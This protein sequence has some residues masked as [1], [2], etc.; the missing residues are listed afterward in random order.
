MNAFKNLSKTKLFYLLICSFFISNLANAQ[1]PILLED[2]SFKT[3]EKY[4]RIKNLNTYYVAANNRLVSIKKGRNS[5]TIQRFNLEDL[6]EDIK[7]RQVIEDKGDFQTVMKLNDKAVV[8]YTKSNRAYGQKVS[9][10]GI[11]AE[12]PIQLVNDKESVAKDFGFKSTYGYDAGGRINQFVFKKS[13]NGR[14]LLVLFRIKTADNKP[15][16]VGVTVFSDGLNLLWRRKVTMPHPSNLMQGEDFAIDDNGNFYMTASFF[17]EVSDDKDKIETSYVTEV[18]RITENSGPVAANKLSISGHSITDGVI[19]F[20]NSGKARVSGFYANNANKAE[21]SGVFSATLG[22]DGAV[23]SITKGD[24]SG[25]INQKWILEREARIN[26]G[27]QKEDDIKDL[28][29][30]RVNDVILNADG[31]TTILGEQR[32]VETFTT[33]SSSGSRTTYRYYY[34]DIFA[35]KLK[36]DNS[37]AWVH[38]LPKNQLGTVSKRSMSYL[39]FMNGGKHYLFYIDDFTNLKRSFEEAP[40]RYFDGKKEFIYMTSYVIDD[41]TGEVTKEA[42]LTGSDIRNSR[43]DVLELTKAATLP[44]KDMIFEAYDGKKNNLLLKVSLAQ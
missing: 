41:S 29:N 42:I 19:E 11:V 31:S 26:E 30:L 16:K 9:L 21:I 23:S 39:N 7:Q 27:T 24:I 18:Y 12:K 15:D 25:Q 37:L 10:T 3:G 38:K 17:D 2:F 6:K 34:R 20:D 4:K 13:P 40:T 44:N 36:S 28:E 35:F 1:K 43:L 8:F 22:D 5:M 33:S 14:K 32:Y